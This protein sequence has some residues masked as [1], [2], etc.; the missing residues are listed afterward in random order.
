MLTFIVSEHGSIPEHSTIYEDGYEIIVKEDILIQ[1]LSSVII[2]TGLILKCYLYEF[3]HLVIDNGYQNI[4]KIENNII[5]NNINTP[6]DIKIINLTNNNVTIE[7]N[8]KIC[9]FYSKNKASLYNTIKKDNEMSKEVQSVVAEEVKAKVVEEVQP[10]VVEEVQ[11]VV[12]E[13]QKVVAEEVKVEV[14]V[15][16]DMHDDIHNDTTNL[17]QNQINANIAKR[18]YIRKKKMTINLP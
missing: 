7:K 2:K 8:N 9:H 4:L 6:Y 13:V 12:E 15:H 1:P 16:D 17:T 14:V 11:P 10:T 5:E 18:K 3:I